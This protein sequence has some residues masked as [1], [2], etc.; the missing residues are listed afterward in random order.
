MNTTTFHT[1][2]LIIGAGPTGLAAA[3]LAL[4]HGYEVDLVDDNFQSGGQIWRGGAQTQHDKRAQL[5]AKMLAQSSRLRC[6][7]QSKV[8][9][10]NGS[11]NQFSAVLDHVQNTTS[12]SSRI[13]AKR[14]I[15]AT[16]ARELLLPFPGW[17]L[18]GVTGAGGLQALAKSG[19]P[20]KGK[21]VVVAGTG[22][23]LLAVAASLVERG[24]IVT[25]IVEQTSFSKLKR[26]AFKLFATPSKLWQAL[27][28]AWKLRQQ[29]YWSTAFVLEALGGKR[30][31]RVVIQHAG[32]R[33]TIE[34]DFLACGFGLV[35]NLELA[36]GIGCKFDTTK[37]PEESFMRSP[38]TLS[39]RL[40]SSIAGVFCAGET[41]GVGG[42]DL[43]LVEGRLAASSAVLS[44]KQA[45]TDNTA[46][47]ETE[48]QQQLANT[49]VEAKADRNKWQ[50]FASNLESTFA[51]R[52]ELTQ[53]CRDD[54]IVCRCEDVRFQELK[55][56]PDWRSAKL[57]TRCGMGPC[58]G[59]VCG[60]ANRL[61][62]GWERDLGRMPLSAS[63]IES[64]LA[65][66]ESKE[67]TSNQEIT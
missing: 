66:V 5:L 14:V 51:L 32:E 38:L 61:L 42:V 1:D 44:L 63:P 62:F 64:L 53:L 22:P 37:L 60:T 33:K 3:Q 39:P 15:I 13:M 7:F 52:E 6:H 46:P 65:I 10:L 17:T 47:N 56:H 43:A 19:Y 11:I 36:A 4:E 8:V 31:E 41:T 67:V 48:A 58:Q 16:G 21:R 29:Q 54:T 23:L 34:C 20:V 45:Q 24:A 50:T 18:P 2:L 35:P 25:H 57:H 27:G 40:E 9:H 55:I 59:R 30:L 49:I 28:L 12:T 26:F